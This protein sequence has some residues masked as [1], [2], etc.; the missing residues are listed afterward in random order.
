MESQ[1]W[2]ALVEKHGPIVLGLH[3]KGVQGVIEYWPG[4]LIVGVNYHHC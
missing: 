3:S 4:H 2:K 1:I